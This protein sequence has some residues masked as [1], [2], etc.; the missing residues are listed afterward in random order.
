M[1]WSNFWKHSKSSRSLPQQKWTKTFHL[2]KK[3]EPSLLMCLALSFAQRRRES[4]S[5]WGMGERLCG[6]LPKLTP[7][8][9][10]V[11][12]LKTLIAFEQQR[13]LTLVLS[14][15]SEGTPATTQRV[16]YLWLVLVFLGERKNESTKSKSKAVQSATP[17][18]TWS[19]ENMPAK[20][21]FRWSSLDGGQ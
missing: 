15:P 10:F 2:L 6:S 1:S 21:F 3:E 13:L 4:I 12:P 11:V 5:V 20:H 17:F 7:R 18:N 9:A 8:S 14:K 16:V 19:H